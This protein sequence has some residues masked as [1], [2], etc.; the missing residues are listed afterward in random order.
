[1]EAWSSKQAYLGWYIESS[2]RDMD[3]P[4][5]EDEEGHGRCGYGAPVKPEQHGI[6][7]QARVIL[8]GDFVPGQLTGGER[9]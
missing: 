5:D 6:A 4:E 7:V 3:V 8:P 2:V 9:A 1:M